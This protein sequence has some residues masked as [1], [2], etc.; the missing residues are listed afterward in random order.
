MNIWNVLWFLQPAFFLFHVQSSDSIQLDPRVAKYVSQLVK[1]FRANPKGSH[2]DH[3]IC[4]PRRGENLVDFFYPK[5]FILC[6]MDHYRLE[7]NCPLHACP[8]RPGFFTDEVSKNSPRN[9]RL[10]YDLRGN[11]LLIQRMYTC[12]FK[13]STHRYLS[14]SEQILASI[15]QIY[16]QSCF[17]I[18]LLYRSAC[19]KQLVDLVE[20]QILQG[21]SFLKISE[22]LAAM[23]FKEFCERSECFA[24]L[25][26]SI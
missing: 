23:N 14:A 22:G 20:T 11:L 2:F 19:T 10:V 25:I 21:V 26:S 9:P 24:L 7:I 17:P 4:P 12:H 16:R 8:L 15:P 13:G 6:P 18:V 5:I 3:V 1:A